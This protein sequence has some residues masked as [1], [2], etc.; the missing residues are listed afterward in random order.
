MRQI[1]IFSE[2]PWQMSLGER[3][4]LE[5]VL[6]Q[7][8][9][10]LAVEIGT[11]EGGSLSRIAAHAEEIHS[12]DLVEPQ[13]P[14]DELS[15]VTL[16]TGDSHALLP[17]VLAGFAAEGRNVDFVLVDGDHSPEGVR[18][19]LQDLLDSPALSQTVIV[20]HDINNERVREGVDAVP[21]TAWPKVAHVDLDWVPG[22][23]FRQPELLHELWG[24]LGLVVVDAARLAYFPGSSVVQDRY[25]PAHP[26]FAEGRDRIAARER[27]EAEGRELARDEGLQSLAERVA[28][29]EGE[30]ARMESVSEHHRRLWN[31]LMGSWSWKVTSPLRRAKDGVRGV[32]G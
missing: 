22:Y 13:I 12:F 24:G 2:S 6:S 31:D 15:N 20:I 17:E 21:Y 16:H 3:A 27:A 28:E 32:I 11:A 1:E 30:L 10:S 29:L 14:M 9:P 7:L 5:G 19:D 8:K 26:V 23:V 25:Y 18:Q 4:A